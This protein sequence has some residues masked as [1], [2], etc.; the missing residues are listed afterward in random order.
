MANPFGLSENPFVAG[1][2]TRLIFQYEKRIE[3]VTLLRRRITEGASFVTVTGN[4][5]CGKTSIVT[6]ALEG[7]NPNEFLAKVAFISHPSLTPSELLEAVCIEFGAPLPNPPSKPQTLASLEHHLRDLRRQGFVAVLVL[8]EGHGLKTEL[9]EETRL[10]SN[11]KH[12]GRGLLQTV[13]VGL[14]ELERRL[15]LPELAQLRQRIAV[16]LRMTPLSPE[17][18]AGY[19]QHRVTA[20]GGDGPALFPAETC[21]EIHG[22]TNGFPRDINTLAGGALEHAEQLGDPEVT[23][24]HVRMAAGECVPGSRPCSAARAHRSRSSSSARRASAAS[25]S[26][27]APR[28]RAG[29]EPSTRRA[30]RKPPSF[31][32]TQ[33][34]ART[35][36]PGA[37]P[38]SVPAAEDKPTLE[39][40]FRSGEVSADDLAADQPGAD[41]WASSDRLG[42]DHVQ[43]LGASV[44]LVGALITVLLITG[45]WNPAT[46][47]STPAPPQASART[48]TATE[49]TRSPARMDTTPAP[50][51][52][53]PVLQPILAADP[54][55]PVIDAAERWGDGMRQGYGF[56]V[57]ATSV[58]D[59]AIAMLHKINRVAKLPCR[60]VSKTTGD[61]Y[62][63]VVG[64]FPTRREAQKALNDLF[65]TPIAKR[66]QLVQI[67]E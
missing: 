53:A 30:E 16:H 21:E 62:R 11:M 24:D 66:A 8:D 52:I 56:E 22:Y 48:V 63:V 20:V 18:T 35:G 54:A 27:P 60:I 2:D 45:R 28:A 33:H 6:E 40:R 25:T 43:E 47:P 34:A 41:A 49:P 9:L 64:P 1:H 26:R 3:A 13:L 17:E 67:P 31:L 39:Q 42:G 12:E 38:E 32:R 36:P 50:P 14:P 4:S 19:L 57:L 55:L 46:H 7:G 29:T 44:L 10:L 5:G 23:P 65:K 61:P 58:P 59:T 15:G 37:K 51:R